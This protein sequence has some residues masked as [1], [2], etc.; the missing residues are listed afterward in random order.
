[1]NSLLSFPERGKWGKSSWR[2]NCSGFVQLALL[3]HFNPRTVA[4]PC[5]GG[6]TTGDVIRE[7]NES[8]ADNDRINYFGFDLHSGFN[9]L[10]DDFGERTKRGCDWVFFHPPYHSM[11]RYS[12]ANG[13]WGQ[14]KY[15]HGHPDDLSC[16]T[17]YEEFLSKMRVALLNIYDG[18]KTGGNYSMLVGDLRKGGEYFSLQSDLQ[19]IAPGK[20]QG[21]LIKAQHNCVSDRAN[22]GSAKLIR[23]A[24]EYVL[25]FEKTAVIAGMLDA[26]IAASR[27]LQDL[28]GATWRAVCHYA[29]NKLGGRGSLDDIYRVIRQS[30]EDRV[31]RRPNW[32]AKV[33][34]TLQKCAEPISRGIWALPSGA[35]DSFIAAA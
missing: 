17:T 33:R 27:R 16:C 34:Q 23:I 30:V 19:Q 20:L 18:I 21:I 35:V 4:D 14:Q 31:R 25:N 15:P 28:S 2:G 8:R 7:L 12:G 29:L 1:M 22:Y 6:G 26:T 24:H 11:V 32:E 13:M 10:R 9:L 3:K 5:E